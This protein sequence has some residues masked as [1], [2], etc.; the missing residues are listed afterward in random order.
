MH[1]YGTPPI[2]WTMEESPQDWIFT[3][4]FGQYGG[5]LRNSFVWIHGTYDSAREE[6]VRCFGLKWA[7]QYANEKAAGVEEYNLKEIE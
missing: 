4:G 2:I 1:N 6:M 7:M 3:F 5:K